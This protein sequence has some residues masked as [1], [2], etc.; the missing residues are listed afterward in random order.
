MP[1]ALT[2][3]L[4]FF[5]LVLYC[6][7]ID[8]WTNWSLIGP[9]LLKEAGFWRWRDGRTQLQKPVKIESMNGFGS[10]FDTASLSDI[11]IAMPNFSSLAVLWKLRDFWCQISNLKFQP[12]PSVLARSVVTRMHYCIAV[13]IRLSNNPGALILPTFHHKGV[14]GSPETIFGEKSDKNQEKWFF[15]WFRIK[16]DWKAPKLREWRTKS[17]ISATDGRILMIFSPFFQFFQMQKLQPPTTEIQPLLHCRKIEV[18]TRFEVSTTIP[19][20][21]FLEFTK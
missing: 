4:K 2:D 10:N 9:F 17:C 6:V 21:H 14:K 15:R 19:W 18:L 3:D 5:I 12:N 11:P 16:A 13:I 1:W 20:F 8:F 7:R